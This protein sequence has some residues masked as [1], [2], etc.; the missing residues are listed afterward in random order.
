[1]AQKPMFR[2]L[3]KES[4]PNLKVYEVVMPDGTRW[5]YS[6]GQMQKINPLPLTRLREIKDRD[7]TFAH[8]A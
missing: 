3:S 4:H 8:S 2:V 5:R 1:M 7:Q 6:Y